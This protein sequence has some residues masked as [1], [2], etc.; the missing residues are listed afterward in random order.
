MPGSDL[1]LSDSAEALS[2]AAPP[3]VASPEAHRQDHPDLQHVTS[4]APDNPNNPSDCGTSE[5]FIICVG[6]DTIF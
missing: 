5:G 1:C 4:L 2:A 6:V 3:R